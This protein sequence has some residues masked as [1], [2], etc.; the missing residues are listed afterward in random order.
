MEYLSIL[1]KRPFILLIPQNQKTL[2]TTK[3]NQKALFSIYSHAFVNKR[4]YGRGRVPPTD[5]I[6]ALGLGIVDIYEKN[7]SPIQRVLND[8][9]LTRT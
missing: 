8:L 7:S 5:M 2:K 9:F 4:Q 1:Q 6:Q 3:K